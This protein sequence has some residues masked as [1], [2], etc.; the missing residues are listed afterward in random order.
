MQS[1]D[2]VCKDFTYEDS[3]KL[4]WLKKWKPMS[5]TYLVLD[6]K[7]GWK[8]ASCDGKHSFSTIEM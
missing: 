7:L 5:Y 8:C 4:S 1:K 3:S 2:S 6:T